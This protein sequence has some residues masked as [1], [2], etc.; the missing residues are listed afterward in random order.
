MNDQ[1]RRIRQEKGVIMGKTIQFEH[2]PSTARGKLR[3]AHF[4]QKSI[5]H[6]ESFADEG[7]GQPRVG[8]IEVKARRSGDALRGKFDIT[9]HIDCDPRVISSGPVPDASYTREMN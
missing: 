2:N 8:K 1:A 5:I 9:F 6:V 3:D 7:R 4:F